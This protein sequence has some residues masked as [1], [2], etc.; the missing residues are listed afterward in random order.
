[1]IYIGQTCCMKDNLFQ[2]CKPMTRTPWHAAFTAVPILYISFAQLTSLYCEEQ[3]Y[4]YIHISDCVQTVHE[5]PLLPNNT[6]VKL[7]TQIVV[8]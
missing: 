8:V 2:G 6:A 1:M 4:I 3:V 5:L 7:F